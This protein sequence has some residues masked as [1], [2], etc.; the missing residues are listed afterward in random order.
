MEPAGFDP[1]KLS[2][3]H[4]KLFMIVSFLDYAKGVSYFFIEDRCLSIIKLPLNASNER[5]IC[6]NKEGVDTSHHLLLWIKF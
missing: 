4:S 1:E 5:S 2:T 3:P 6:Y